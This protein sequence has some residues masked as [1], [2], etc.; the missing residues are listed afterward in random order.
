M[1]PSPSQA[2]LHNFT[3]YPFLTRLNVIG[4]HVTHEHHNLC[5]WLQIEIKRYVSKSKT[6]IT[7]ILWSSG[8]MIAIE[9]RKREAMVI[10]TF[11][12]KITELLRRVS[13][14]AGGDRHRIVLARSYGDHK[15][16]LQKS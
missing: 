16:L 12:A 14:E 1:K 8:G 3:E 10:T 9:S 6:F 4:L 15:R 7:K 5:V 2:H 13:G 11:T